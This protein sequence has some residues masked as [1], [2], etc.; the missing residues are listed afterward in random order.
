VFLLVAAVL[1][2]GAPVVRK[3]LALVQTVPAR[4]GRVTVA[5]EGEALVVREERVV[6]AEVR[7]RVRPVARE[8]ERVPRGALVA[9]VTPASGAEPAEAKRLEAAVQETERRAILDEQ[10]PLAQG[11][12]GSGASGKAIAADRKARVAE[13]AVLARAVA[14]QE[15]FARADCSGTVSY[16]VDGLEGILGPKSLKEIMSGETPVAK[17]ARGAQAATVRAGDQV[18]P[19]RPVA[20]VVDNF[21]VWFLLDLP[22]GLEDAALPQMSERIKLRLLGAGLPAGATCRARVAERRDGKDSVRLLLEPVE[23]WPEFGRV[24]LVTL[25]LLLGDYEGVWVP[26]GSL[27]E[28]D[29]ATG[30]TVE[31]WLGKQFQQVSVRGGDRDRVVVDGLAPGTRVW[32]KP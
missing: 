2:V 21:Q 25:Q 22:K 9:R 11:A 32:R 12:G 27:R 15:Q 30:V 8:G 4:Y 28:R 6:F 23:Y 26:R 1:V 16:E 29:G 19:G 31:S 13:R 24:R 20:K 5:R 10:S 14:G 7:G 3:G 17:V 18:E